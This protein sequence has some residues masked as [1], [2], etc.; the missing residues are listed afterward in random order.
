ME[1]GKNEIY[2]DG[3][4][5]T[6]PNSKIKIKNASVYWNYQNVTGSSN[7]YYVTAVPKSIAFENGYWTFRML[8]DRFAKNNVKLARN[9]HDNTCKIYPE[10]SDLV[11]NNLGLMLGFP[12]SKIIKEKT[13]TT[14][15]SVVD[16]NLG[17]RYVTVKCNAVDMEKNFDRYG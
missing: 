10:N 14:S 2:L 17:L 1:T 11:L 8:A 15:S 12:K 9:R 3:F 13:W 16:V 4:I 5:R 6:E 7:D